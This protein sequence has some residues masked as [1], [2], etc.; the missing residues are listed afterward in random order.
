MRPWLITAG[1]VQGSG[2]QARRCKRLHR[3]APE[4]RRRSMAPSVV[5]LG[6]PR[7]VP[8]QSFVLHTFT[9]SGI[10]EIPRV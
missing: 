10:G 6:K 5:I 3:K 4:V 9:I 7:G 1:G 2:G 8:R